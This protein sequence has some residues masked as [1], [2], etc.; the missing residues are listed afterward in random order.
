MRAEEA[1]V[2]REVERLLAEMEQERANDEA[3]DART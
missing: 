1:R 2:H 3:R